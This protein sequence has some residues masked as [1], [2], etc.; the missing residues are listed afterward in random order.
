M[1]EGETF[2]ASLLS[3]SFSDDDIL[4][5]NRASQVAITTV[6]GHSPDGSS[7]DL[8]L[9]DS[10]GSGLVSDVSIMIVIAVHDHLHHNH[11][12]LCR[13]G[14]EQFLVDENTT[15]QLLTTLDREDL[16]SYDITVTVTNTATCYLPGTCH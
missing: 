11:T 5:E 3:L 16:S 8:G 14:L 10:A 12:Y 7:R 4:P 13:A 15:L 9:G 2:S 6:T 1:S